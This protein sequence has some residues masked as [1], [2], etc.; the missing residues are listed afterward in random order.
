MPASHD[1]SCPI[2]D[3]RLGAFLPDSFLFLWFSLSCEEH[4]VA[5]TIRTMKV[6]EF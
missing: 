3:Q 1:M 2:K 4:F 6:L 5:F